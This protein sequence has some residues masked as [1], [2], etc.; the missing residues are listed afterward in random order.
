MAIAA[1]GTSARPA[2]GRNPAQPLTRTR[3]RPPPR[4]KRLGAKPELLDTRPAGVLPNHAPHPRAPPALN[5]TPTPRASNSA[6]RQLRP[7]R[8]A[9]ALTRV[10]GVEGLGQVGGHRLERVEADG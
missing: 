5:A 4:V 2:P 9:E 8:G 1:L 3:A 7:R 10:V 6:A